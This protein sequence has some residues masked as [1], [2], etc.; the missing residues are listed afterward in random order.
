LNTFLQLQSLALDFFCQWVLI[1]KVRVTLFKNVFLKYFPNMI[2]TSCLFL[3]KYCLSDIDWNGM[4]INICQEA[5]SRTS[6][7]PF[8]LEIPTR[9]WLRNFYTSLFCW[10]RYLIHE[11]KINT[12]HHTFC[13][14]IK[15]K[16]QMISCEHF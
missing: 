10:L 2:T 16:P 14:D 5:Q 4:I 6:M 15:C 12:F 8:G 11:C 3:S 9:R 1:F 13:F 7:G